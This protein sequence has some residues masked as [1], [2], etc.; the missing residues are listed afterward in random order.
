MKIVNHK[1]VA[2]TGDLAVSFVSSPNKGGVIAPQYLIIHYTAGRSAKSSIEW[3]ANP[4]AKAS[5]HLVIGLDGKI[6]QMVEFNKSAWHAGVSK[7]SGLSGL[8]NYS[9]G[10]ELDNPGRLQ[11]TGNKWRSW[12]GAEYPDHLVLEAVHKHQE[13]KAGWHVYTEQQLRACIAVSQLLVSHYKLQ[14]VL[15]HEDVSPFRKEDPGPAFP[16][17]SF[18]SSVL[19]RSDDVA[20]IFKVNTENVNLRVGAGTEFGA[21]AKLKKGTKVEFI[22]SKLNWY[23][24]FVISG[25]PGLTEKEGW[26]YA[27]LL[28]KVS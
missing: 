17:E 25:T 8:N 26:V 5:A 13:V 11:K 7:W 19:G 23:Y 21:I 15:G 3:M 14:D 18:K 22:K 12:F 9:I 27:P 10:I 16:M 2:E 6:T 1:L 4:A 24:I 20:D 28:T